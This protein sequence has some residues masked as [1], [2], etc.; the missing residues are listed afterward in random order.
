MVPECGTEL[1]EQRVSAVSG[2]LYL[3]EMDAVAGTWWGWRGADG[4]VLRGGHAGAADH[5]NQRM[6]LRQVL[7]ALEEVYGAV[8]VVTSAGLRP[9]E[10]TWRR[11]QDRGIL[12][13]VR[14]SL[15]R[16]AKGRLL[17]SS[18]RIEGLLLEGPGQV[19]AREAAWW[20]LVGSGGEGDEYSGAELVRVGTDA[21]VDP[22]VEVGVWCWYASP[23][24]FDL[25]LVEKVSGS[26][27]VETMAVAEALESN[28]GVRVVTDCRHFLRVLTSAG[29]TKRGRCGE[30]ER[31]E[32]LRALLA[33]QG[34]NSEIT[35]KKGHR[36]GGVQ[37][38]ADHLSRGLLRAVV[39]SRALTQQ[40]C[41]SDSGATA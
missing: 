33:L 4:L 35:W 28:K 24:R 10:S 14:S 22:V 29:G 17:G 34:S 6:C 9:R 31:A 40:E 41:G 7:R 36:G 27:L 39:S 38:H 13:S 20:A 3:L 18:L 37:V 19:L 26:S 16:K 32:R 23:G 15:G 11:P 30:A 5:I 21:S 1:I 12:R 25:G 8:C 2:E